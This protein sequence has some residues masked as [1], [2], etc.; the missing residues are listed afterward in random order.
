M[1]RAEVSVCISNYSSH[2]RYRWTNIGIRITIRMVAGKV[3]GNVEIRRRCTRR[4][5]RKFSILQGQFIF[6][7]YSTRN[8]FGMWCILAWLF[9]ICL[10]SAEIVV[11]SD[12]LLFFSLVIYDQ[13]LPDCWKQKTLKN[14]IWLATFQMTWYIQKF[15][16][17]KKTF[18]RF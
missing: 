4:F 8:K 15:W 13:K 9:Q 11:I 6:W 7:N 10:C 1:S 17:P 5:C 3:W 16:I 2:I 12:D 18:T 14:N